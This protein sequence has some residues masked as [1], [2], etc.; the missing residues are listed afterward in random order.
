M[1]SLDQPS[2]NTAAHIASTSRY[3]Y[4]LLDMSSLCLHEYDKQHH[5]QLVILTISCLLKQL[6]FG[7]TAVAFLPLPATNNVTCPP[8]LLDILFWSPWLLSTQ[9]EAISI[10]YGNLF[11]QSLNVRLPLTKCLSQ[12]LLQLINKKS[13]LKLILFTFLVLQSRLHSLFLLQRLVSTNISRYYFFARIW[14]RSQVSGEE[15]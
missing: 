15:L 6:H 4:Y 5:F 12:T 7:L 11:G 8:K 2:T 13:P 9:L 3:I 10:M 14:Q 1:S